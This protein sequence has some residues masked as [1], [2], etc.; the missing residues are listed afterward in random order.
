[1]VRSNVTAGHSRIAPGAA[2]NIVAGD[3]VPEELPPFM[4][5]TASREAE[6]VQRIIEQRY[7][8]CPSLR[9]CEDLIAF[10]EAMADGQ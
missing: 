5:V 2:S 8:F 9:Y 4:T 7:G 1:M 3:V 6:T 10:V